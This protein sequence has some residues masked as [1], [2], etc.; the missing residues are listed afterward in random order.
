MLFVFLR[1]AQKLAA[2][3]VKIDSVASRDEETPAPHRPY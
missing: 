3:R 1:V 2:A